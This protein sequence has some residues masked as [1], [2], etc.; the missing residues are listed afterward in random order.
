MTEISVTIASLLGRKTE[1]KVKTTD[2]VLDLKKRF[3]EKTRVPPNEQ[4]LRLGFKSLADDQQLIRDVPIVDHTKLL[5]NALN[6]V[7]VTITEPNSGKTLSEN[8]NYDS[9]LAALLGTY[10]NNK[11]M[12]QFEKLAFSCNGKV[13]LADT[14]AIHL[15]DLGAVGGG[16]ITVLAVNGALASNLVPA[17]APAK[18]AST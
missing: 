10:V 5:Y 14:E 12:P 16:S 4:K 1:V 15:G 7:S 8:Y 2:T 17:S 13:M 11:D 9:T 18:T 6:K 3:E